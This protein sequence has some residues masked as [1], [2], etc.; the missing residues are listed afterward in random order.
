[1][2]PRIFK[3]EK[4]FKPKDLI[5][6]GLDHIY[7]AEQLFEA[8][9]S[10]FDSAGYLVHMGFELLLK[11]WHLEA[12]VEF[13]GIHSLKELVEQLRAKGQ[14][15]NLT[16]EENDVLKIADSFGELRYPAP[17]HGTEVGSDDWEGI[18]SLLN[19]IWEQTPETFY[20]YY[21]AISH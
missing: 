7:A 3:R 16:E 21:E 6:S 19:K 11:A 15:L 4:G 10:F 14:Q 9:P 2:A 13:S 1:M 12:F 18:H 5:Q 20:D 17:N 8:S